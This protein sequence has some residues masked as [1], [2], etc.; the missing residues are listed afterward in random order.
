MAGA[1]AAMSDIPVPYE[2]A[3]RAERLLQAQEG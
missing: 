3:W 2:N 1:S